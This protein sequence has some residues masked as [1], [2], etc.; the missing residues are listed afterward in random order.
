[1]IVTTVL[2]VVGLASSDSIA[3]SLTPAAVYLLLHGVESQLVTPA[4][5]GRRFEINPLVVFL[6]IVF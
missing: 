6:A 2:G 5:L 4:L 1:M 3:W